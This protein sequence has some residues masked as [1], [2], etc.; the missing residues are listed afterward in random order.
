MSINH[1]LNL[2]LLHLTYNF[3]YL[4]SRKFARAEEFKLETPSEDGWHDINTIDYSSLPKLTPLFRVALGTKDGLLKQIRLLITVSIIPRLTAL[5][6]LTPR[7]PICNTQIYT[8]LKSHT[9]T[10]MHR[11]NIILASFSLER[12]ALDKSDLELYDLYQ[13]L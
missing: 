9:T 13:V 12:S 4:F 1:I 10:T 2:Y 7:A 6:R 3:H 11:E 5:L 8:M